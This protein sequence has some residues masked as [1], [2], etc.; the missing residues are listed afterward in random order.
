M[1]Q[2][3]NAKGMI[4]LLDIK[5]TESNVY[6]KFATLCESP[7]SHI[8]QWTKEG[9]LTRAVFIKSGYVLFEEKQKE[10]VKNLIK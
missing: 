7:P 6:T 1:L 10:D 8:C 3:L 4:D 9:K 5:T 2:D